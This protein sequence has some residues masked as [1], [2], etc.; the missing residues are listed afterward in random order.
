MSTLAMIISHLLIVAICS[1]LAFRE[2]FKRGK[3]RGRDEQWV[4]DFMQSIEK[5]KRRRNSLGQFVA[6]TK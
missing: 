2:G 3:K 5:A 4:D 6:K 1:A